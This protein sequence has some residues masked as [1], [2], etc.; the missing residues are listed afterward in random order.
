[1]IPKHI[2]DLAVEAITKHNDGLTILEARSKLWARRNEYSLMQSYHPDPQNQE[3]IAYIDRVLGEKELTEG[4]NGKQYDN[5]I[6]P[7]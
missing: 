6:R 1:M 4:K 3:I 2:I 7:V 5:G